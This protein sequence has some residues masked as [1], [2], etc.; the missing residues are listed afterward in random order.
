MNDKEIIDMLQKEEEKG[1][2]LMI[3]QYSSYIS[4]IV[5]NMTRQILTPSDMEEI[6]ADVFLKIWRNRTRLQG[7]RLKG[8]LIVTTRNLCKD[9]FKKQHEPF[10]SNEDDWLPLSSPDRLHQIYEQQEQ[11]DIVRKTVESWGEA[12]KEIFICFYYF[13]QKIKEISAHFSMN[14]STVKTKLKRCKEKLKKALEEGGY[15]YE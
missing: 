2:E 10:L 12:D 13:G 8:L 3:D 9:A 6:V 15:E 7:D 11:M 4:T 1:Y 14:P 5:Y